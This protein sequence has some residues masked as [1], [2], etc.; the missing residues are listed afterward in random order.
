M[1][2]DTKIVFG[3]ETLLLNN[4]R[5]IFW[6]GEKMLIFS[7]LHLGKSAHF[8]RHGIA[9]PDGVMQKD[10]T[11]IRELVAHYQPEAL[12]VVGDV[13]HAG[14]NSETLKF[15]ELTD[16]WFP[17]RTLLIKGNHDRFV[18]DHFP[19]KMFQWTEKLTLRGITLMHQPDEGG[20]PCIS[21][22]IHPGVV[23]QARNHQKLKLPCF[24]VS[25]KQLILPAF[26][27]FTGLD[28]DFVRSHHDIFS[29]YVVTPQGVFS[30]DEV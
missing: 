18:K 21:G 15:M 10:L 11:M 12:V 24:L 13:F 7:D 8:R 27:R 25:D 16:G 29:V 28:A 14:V 4:G 26:S 17:E 9:V 23:L 2:R 20:D 30:L 22:H 5:S 3:G 6:P 1:I 19:G